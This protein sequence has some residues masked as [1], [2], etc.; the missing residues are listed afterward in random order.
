MGNLG[1]RYPAYIMVRF[2]GIHNKMGEKKRIF[3]YS[4]QARQLLARC[5][6][7]T[8]H[9]TVVYISIHFHYAHDL[10]QSTPETLF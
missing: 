8:L 6:G 4:L 7:L 3:H 2:L 9:K 10:K 1:T 5:I